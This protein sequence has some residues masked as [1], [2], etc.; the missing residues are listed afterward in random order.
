VT[1]HHDHE[2]DMTDDTTTSNGRT[3][4]DHDAVADIDDEALSGPTIDRRTSMR[5]LAAAG[6]TGLAGCASG[7]GSPASPTPTETDDGMATDTPV[8]DTSDRRGDTMTAAWLIAELNELD[9][10]Y[11]N[12]TFNIALEVNIF[13]GLVKLTQSGEFVGDL[14]TDWTVDGA[15]HTFQ[16][17]DDV[18]FHNGEEFT[19]EDVAYTIRRTINEETPA[20]GELALLKDPNEDGVVVQGD[21]E[22]ELNWEQPYAVAFATLSRGFG[23]AATV[24]NQTALEEMGREQHKLTPVGTGPF[25]IDQHVSGEEVTLSRH[26]DYHETD[27]SGTQLPYLDGLNVN[28]VSEPATAVSGTQSGSIEFLQSV[29][30]QSKSDLEQASSITVSSKPLQSW[31]GLEFNMTRE[32]FSSKKFRKG[33]A[34]L[35]DAERFVQ[36]ALFGDALPAVGPLNPELPPTRDDKPQVQAYDPEEGERLIRESGYEGVE[37][38]VMARS[39]ELRMSKVMRQMLDESSVITVELNQVPASEFGQNINNMTYDTWIGGAGHSADPDGSLWNFYIGKDGIWNWTGYDNEQ[40][41]EWLEQQRATTDP[42]ERAELIFKIE[43]RIMEDAPHAFTHHQNGTY[44]HQSYVKGMR[45]VP[46]LRP[47][48]TVWLDN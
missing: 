25:Q 44:A 19:A 34:K 12:H 15:T 14:A 45:H 30:G 32:P 33:V 17:R 36:T 18:T 48:H 4:T 8:N 5:I 35:I 38:N 2:T 20:A 27:D 6:L 39:S 22:V 7:P 23:R 21:Y 11:T 13:N 31:R 16:L 37:F 47:F 41:T 28:M 10:A 24:I 42:E 40:V 29:P 1:D 26:E 9:P 3:D 46:G 43:D